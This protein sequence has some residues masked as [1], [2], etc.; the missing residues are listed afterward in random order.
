MLS[1]GQNWQPT[2]VDRVIETFPTSTRVAKVKTDA[3]IGFLKGLGNP[4]GS[5]SLAMELVGS[6]LAVQLGLF[7]P[8]FAV[9]DLAEIEVPM[10]DHGPMSFGPAFISRENK[11]ITSDGTNL[12]VSKLAN[13]DEIALLVM[14]DTWIRNLDRCPPPDYMDPTPR[15]DNLCFA[16]IGQK[17]KLMVIDQSHCF[18]EGQLEDGLGGSEFVNDNRIYGLFPEFVQYIREASLRRAAAAIESVDAVTIAEIVN[19]VPMAWGPTQA[20]RD[21]WIDRIISRQAKVPTF[22]INALLVQAQLDV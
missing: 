1:S 7:V 6:E 21:C 14:F 15:R 16:P 22:V 11:C 4:S 5:Q 20:I 18:V 13:S 8:D 10:Q 3:G 12:L 19:S 2:Y 9:F 17:L